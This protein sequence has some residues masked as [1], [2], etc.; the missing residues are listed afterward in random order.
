MFNVPLSSNGGNP[1]F[2][3]P[4]D[5][6]AIDPASLQFTD[7]G[8]GN[9]WSYFGCFPNSNTGL[10]AFQAQGD[11]YQLADPQ[12]IQ[13]NDSIRIT[14]FGSTSA[15]VNPQWNLA[16]KTDIGGYELFTN[17]ELG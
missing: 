8:V 10:T 15:P 13:P 12:A 4:D 17:A 9:D 11:S 2:P 6:Y 1:N 14:G 16:Q 3:S 5:Q 7:G